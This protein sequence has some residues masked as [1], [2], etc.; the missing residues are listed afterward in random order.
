M[1]VYFVQA[2]NGDK[3]FEGGAFGLPDDVCVMSILPVEPRVVPFVEWLDSELMT[4]YETSYIAL[5]K[6]NYELGLEEISIV[7]KEKG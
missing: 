4:D 7:G 6:D 5:T 1:P 3:L 2:A